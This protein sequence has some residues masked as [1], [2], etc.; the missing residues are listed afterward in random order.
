MANRV[1][2]KANE[3]AG[4]DAG[5]AGALVKEQGQL[6]ALAEL[7]ADGAAAGGLAGSLKEV[8]GERRT[9]RRGRTG[10]G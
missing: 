1:G 2:V 5:E 6:G 8:H 7:E 9:K 4:L 10:H 3:V